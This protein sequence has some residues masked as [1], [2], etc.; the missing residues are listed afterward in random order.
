MLKHAHDQGYR[1]ALA[2]FSLQKY[3]DGTATP[4]TVPAAPP[5]APTFG[6][7]EVNKN[8]GFLQRT[9]GH[10][11]NLGRGL[12]G[13]YGDGAAPTTPVH[14]ASRAAAKAQVGT[15]LKGLA[16]PA[17][18]TAGGLYAAKKICGKKDK[19]PQR[20]IG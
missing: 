2:V 7:S 15:S 18:A 19:E 17:L 8:L 12:K 11:E 14:E 4:A 16:V 6:A 10:A 20:G 9:R 13:W 5:A 1:D 3:A